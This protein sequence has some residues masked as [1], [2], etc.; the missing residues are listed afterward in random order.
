MDQNELSLKLHHISVP[1]GASKMISEPMVFSTQTAHVPCSRLAQSAT[2]LNEL[3]LEPRHLA[4]PSGASK[5]I[6]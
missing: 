1:S 3:T 4:I 6:S 2:D 5:T